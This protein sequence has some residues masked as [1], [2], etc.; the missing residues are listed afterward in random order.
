MTSFLKMDSMEVEQEKG[1]IRL[2]LD[3]YIQERL[4]ENQAY[5]KKDL[6]PMKVQPGVLLTLVPYIKLQNDLLQR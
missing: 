2:R 1:E 4:I 6:K 3:K 5:I